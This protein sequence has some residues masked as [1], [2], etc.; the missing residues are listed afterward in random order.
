[1]SQQ[2]HHTGCNKLKE[3]NPENAFGDILDGC[4]CD[5]EDL[6][7]AFSCQAMDESPHKI[8]RSI[9]FDKEYAGDDH[10]YE[11]HEE[12]LPETAQRPEK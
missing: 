12:A 4:S 6:L 8:G 10:R 2:K 1:M 7:A 3:C 11:K 5:R 9:G